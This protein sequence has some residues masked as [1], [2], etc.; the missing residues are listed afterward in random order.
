LK[1]RH[2][3]LASLAAFAAGIATAGLGSDFSMIP[4]LGAMW[5]TVIWLLRIG[6]R[7][8]KASSDAVSAHNRTEQQRASARVGEAPC[9]NQ[10]G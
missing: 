1:A 10:R 3:V 9:R 7:E 4:F 8:S 2:K 6:I 5:I